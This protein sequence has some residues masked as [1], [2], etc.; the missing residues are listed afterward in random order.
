ME[1]WKIIFQSQFHL[2][3]LRILLGYLQILVALVEDTR[4]M[5][6]FTSGCK[7][8]FESREHAFSF[9][10][11][12][13]EVKRETDSKQQILLTKYLVVIRHSKCFGD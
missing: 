9:Q 10:K 1:L 3:E 13:S 2:I 12:R 6:I 4:S 8:F 7:E 11:L 5:A